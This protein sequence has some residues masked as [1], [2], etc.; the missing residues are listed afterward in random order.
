MVKCHMDGTGKY[1]QY[2]IY[3]V[4][5][6]RSNCKKP[7]SIILQQSESEDWG[8]SITLP[9]LAVYLEMWNSDLESHHH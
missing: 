3:I 4:R 9:Q 8:E 7:E 1:T 5:G 2:T 6:T